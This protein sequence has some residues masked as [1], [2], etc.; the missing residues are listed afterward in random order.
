MMTGKDEIHFSKEGACNL[1]I[2][3]QL[4]S[5]E[6]IYIGAILPARCMYIFMF[7]YV[8]MIMKKILSI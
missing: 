2:L 5:P 8:A 6:N 4:I 1:V 7:T 3:N